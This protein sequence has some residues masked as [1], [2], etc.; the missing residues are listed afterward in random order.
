M[1]N[2]SAELPFIGEL[3]DY[4]LNKVEP[5]LVPEFLNTLSPNTQ[6]LVMYRALSMLLR[7][8]ATST[9]S[10][11]PGVEELRR[12]FC[13]GARQFSTMIL[14]PDELHRASV[15]YLNHNTGQSHG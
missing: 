12:A 8:R 6:L 7:E 10:S 9:P 5:S 4:L 15:V 1:G 13:D 2:Q 14:T 11:N 3:T